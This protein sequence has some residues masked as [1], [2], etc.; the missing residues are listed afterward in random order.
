MPF[1]FRLVATVLLPV[2]MLVSNGV[3]A[4]KP[5]SVRPLVVGT[6][7]APPFSMK[8]AKGAWTGISIDLWREIAAE[9]NLPFEFRET[10][11]P[12]LLKGVSDGSLDLAV[13][14]LTVTAD[15]EKVL[16]FTQPYFHTGLGI[17]V[18]HKNRN[19]WLA[20][21][22]SF[23]SFQILRIICGMVLLMLMTGL[24][25]WW[26]ERKG[27]PDHFRRDR[28]AG[29]G[30]GIW[31]SAVTM[32]TVGYGDKAPV[33]TGGRILAVFWMFLGIAV[34][35]VLTAHIT[36]NLTLLQ[37]SSPIRGPEDLIRFRVG[38]VEDTTSGI[39]LKENR[40]PFLSFE[41]PSEGL[42]ALDDGTIE[43]LVYDRPLLLYLVR[44]EFPGRLEVLPVT[45]LPQDYGIALRQR[46]PLREPINRVLL[47][48]IENPAWEGTISQYLGR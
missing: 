43:A 38:S 4:E 14:A 47:E 27:N 41:T 44:N 37:L 40:I 26:F 46:S 29:I 32:T 3:A 33:T 34:I 45:F 18:A 12:G 5:S 22:R 19:P 8:T 48:I 13:A 9:L 21:L 11:L 23:F 7:E 39:Y 2:G 42:R 30:A 36:S 15:R 24:L 1:P 35:A 16:D 28:K 20:V 6:K 31:W 25:M 17:A 10:D